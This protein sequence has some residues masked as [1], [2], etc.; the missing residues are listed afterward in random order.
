MTDV[1]CL[2]TLSRIDFQTSTAKAKE[3]TMDRRREGR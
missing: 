3:L 1:R 2:R